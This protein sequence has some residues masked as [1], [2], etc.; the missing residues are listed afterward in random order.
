MSLSI[1]DWV[2][3]AISCVIS[4]GVGLL[5]TQSASQKGKEGFYTAHRSLPWWAIGFSNCATYQSGGAGFVMLVLVF[6]LAG[7][8][9]WWAS[10]IMWM[11]LVAVIWAPLW[12]RMRIVTTAELITLRYGEN[13]PAYVARR[14]Y[15]LMMFSISVLVIAYITGSFT[16]TVAPLVKITELQTLLIFGGIT[17]LYSMFGGLGAV[18]FVDVIQF[19][20]LMG[21]V[22]AFMFFAIPQF[23]G[24]EHILTTAGAV[25]AQSLQQFPPV[26]GVDTLSVIMLVILGFVLAGSPTAGEGMTAQRFMAAKDEKHAIGGQLFNAFLALSFRTFPLIVM[27]LIAV[28]MFWCPELEKNVG[29]APKGL[30]MLQDP[31]HAWGEVIKRTTLPNGFRGLLLAVEIAAFMSTLSSLI[32]W[33][34]S[35]LVNDYLKAFV[36]DL[37]PKTETWASRLATLLL[38]VFAAVIAL[39]Y[40]KNIVDWFMFINSAMV[41]FILPLAVYRF[42]WGRFNVWGELSATVIGLP[43][44]IIIWFVL[45]FKDKPYWQGLGLLFVSGAVVQ[46]MVALATP[47]DAPAVLRNFYK[48]CRPFGFWRSVTSSDSGLTPSASGSRILLD[49][50]LGIAACLGLVIA[51]NG[52]LVKDWLTGGFGAVAAVV[53]GGIMIARSGKLAVDVEDE[54]NEDASGTGQQDLVEQAKSAA[55]PELCSAAD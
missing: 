55:A 53:F 21:G 8:W 48:R 45:G 28:T 44:S 46:A 6:G 24:W 50:V 31:M 19:F 38:F 1:F 20:I 22:I 4:L 34:G 11:P 30:T 14:I 16:K 33:G 23:G 41:S 15:A 40:V 18:V 29:P 43:L 13:R 5:F 35:F 17:V 2:I 27:G 51:T 25:R 52:L 42:F 9:L 32:N 37:K 10:W 12:R 39:L 26:A 54:E 3:V 47:P 7:N 36:P 49:S